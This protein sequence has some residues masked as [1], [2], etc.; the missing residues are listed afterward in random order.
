MK[1]ETKNTTPATADALPVHNPA[2]DNNPAPLFPHL[3]K[4]V[5]KDATD[6]KKKAR[7]YFVT[8]PQYLERYL[9]PAKLNAYKSGKINRARAIELATARAYKEIDKQTDDKLAKIERASKAGEL[10]AVDISVEWT[11]SRVWGYNPRANVRTFAK[12]EN[13]ETVYNSAN[14]SASGCGYDKQSAAISEAFNACPELLKVLYTAEEKRLRSK[15]TRKQSRGDCIGYG[16]GGGYVLPYFEGGCGVSCYYRIF[17]NCG[18]KFE[19]TAT[20]KTF[21]AYAITKTA[22]KICIIKGASRE[23]FKAY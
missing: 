11:R 21:D 16:C 1:Q 12:T 9:T 20:Y 3:I 15:V 18:Y 14:G 6:R 22:T 10:F 7:A 19:Q 4:A 23:K 5:Q 2:T 8:Y 17:Y 13:G